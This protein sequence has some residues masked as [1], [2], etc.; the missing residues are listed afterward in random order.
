MPAKHPNPI[1]VIATIPGSGTVATSMLHP[2]EIIPESGVLSSTT[3]KLQVPFGS[4]PL[5]IES[6][7]GALELPAGAGLGNSNDNVGNCRVG[8]KV[9]EN[10]V[11]SMGSEFAAESSNV[12]VKSETENLVLP[13]TSL[14]SMETCPLGPANRM[15]RSLG[16]VCVK[17]CSVTVIWLMDCPSKP[18]T[19]IVDGYK[20]ATVGGVPESLIAIAFVFEK[21]N[22]SAHPSTMPISSTATKR[23]LSSNFRSVVRLVF[24]FSGRE[25]QV[26]RAEMKT[27]SVRMITRRGPKG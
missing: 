5:K 10:K 8:L 11:E 14:I 24:I 7:A 16:N 13:P 20:A 3:N 9:P 27:E 19:E 25:F 1:T 2:R 18:L 23:I 22:V 17:P 4:V 12:S 15:S 21:L 6:A 26:F